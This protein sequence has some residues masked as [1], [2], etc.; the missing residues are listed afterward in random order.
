VKNTKKGERD[1]ESRVTFLKRG[2]DLA[3][4]ILAATEEV[5]CRKLAELK[6]DLTALREVFKQLRNNEKIAGC[7]TW[8]AF[9]EQK[10]HRGV[11]AVQHVLK[12]SRP[13]PKANN[14][15]AQFKEGDVDDTPIGQPPPADEA[16]EWPDATEAGVPA[17]KSADEQPI[18]LV[19]G[20][21]PKPEPLSDEEKLDRAKKN[22]RNLFNV[23]Q[24]TP[25]HIQKQ[26]TLLLNG[27]TPY[28]QFVVTV[29]EIEV[30]AKPRT[31]DTEN[32]GVVTPKQQPYGL[33][34]TRRVKKTPVAR[35]NEKTPPVQNAE[36]RHNVEVE[37]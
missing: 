13:E 21:K 5:F 4:G 19:T 29:E 25:E 10:L 8:T 2:E 20:I 37:F 16:D 23:L 26:L 22:V 36:P 28:R 32:T 35:W 30:P 15:R 14:V 6:N 12:G 9:C 11:R 31:Y 33:E 18:D 1:F 34:I 27:V 7:E 24:D 17:T 3:S